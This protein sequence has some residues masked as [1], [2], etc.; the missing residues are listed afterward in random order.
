LLVN[1]A[2][3]DASGDRMLQYIQEGRLKHFDGI[4]YVYDL[5][6]P[7]S[8]IQLEQFYEEVKRAESGDFVSVVVGNKADLIPA[9]ISERPR[10]LESNEAFYLA[11]K[12][13]ERHRLIHQNVSA[14]LNSCVADCFIL[15]IKE[16]LG[17][18]RHIRTSRL[19]EE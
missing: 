18:K 11:S 5:T 14:K 19:G 13:G 3:W 7:H 10:G 4:L 2:V 1:L 9:S 12:F 8:V 6:N 17:L 16:I 15:I